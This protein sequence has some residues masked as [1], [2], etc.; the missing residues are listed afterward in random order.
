MNITLEILAKA[1]KKSWSRDTCYPK[2]RDKWSPNKPEI[3]QCFVT[4]LIINDYFGGL[5]AYD[6][7]LNH[8]FNILPN[9]E[10]IDLTKSQFDNAEPKIDRRFTRERIDKRIT[11]NSL[12]RYKILKKRVQTVLS[13]LN[14]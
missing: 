7:E 1:L 8:Y 2:L 5:I 10:I 4:A 13:T 9:G 3:G 11:K 14:K 6:K 12:E